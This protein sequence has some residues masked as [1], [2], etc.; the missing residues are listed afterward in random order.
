MPRIKQKNK[1]S[2]ENVNYYA[3]KSEWKLPNTVYN[4]A[5]YWEC[6]NY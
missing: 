6:V 3:R 4:C 1:F 5:I 2:D